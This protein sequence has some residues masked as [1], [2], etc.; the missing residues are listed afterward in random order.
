MIILKY[1]ALISA[2]FAGSE[3]KIDNKTKVMKISLF[4]DPPGMG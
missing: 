2:A 1:E 4:M 3:I